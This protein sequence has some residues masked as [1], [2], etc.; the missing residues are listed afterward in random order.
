MGVGC[1]ELPRAGE[2]RILRGEGSVVN[3]DENEPDE[4][5]EQ[6]VD[7]QASY[8]ISSQWM[9]SW[10]LY[11]SMYFFWSAV[12]TGSGSIAGSAKMRE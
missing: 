9:G 10:I 7:E 12:S 2:P 1:S 6:A 8:H 5:D 11:S 3:D 4:Q